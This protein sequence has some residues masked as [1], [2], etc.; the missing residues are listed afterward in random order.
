[1][2][3]SAVG[4]IAAYNIFGLEG[5]LATISSVT[6]DDCDA[7]IVLLYLLSCERTL[8]SVSIFLQSIIKKVLRFSLGD[9]ERERESRI[10]EAK[11][12]KVQFGR[13]FLVNK[14][15]GAGADVA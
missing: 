15:A 1:L 11:I 12:T 9:S 10:I 14:Y 4:A 2:S 8:H 5:L 7:T 6:K 13:E 3:H